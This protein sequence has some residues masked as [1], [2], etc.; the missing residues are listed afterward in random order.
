MATQN[1]Q[2]VVT[3]TDL[4]IRRFKRNKTA[5]VGVFL[6]LFVFIFSFIGPI[7]NPYSEYGIFIL[8][9]T[10]KDGVTT[11]EEL[12]ATDVD[13]SAIQKEGSKATVNIKAKPS[14]NHLLGTD[15]DGRDVFTRLMYGGRIS[16]TVG[17]VAVAIQLLIGITLG[18]IAGYY[19]KYI[20]GLIMRVVDIVNCLPTLP[21][22]MIL[23]SAM[24]AVKIP[25][26]QRI[27]YLMI[28][29]G[30]LSSPSAAR[31]IRGQILS[32]RELE[33]MYA[34]EAIGLKTYQKIIKHL[35][36][37]VM[38]QIIVIATLS[39]GGVILLESSLSFLGIGLAFPY[40]SWGNMVTIIN[41]RFVMQ[42]VMHAW[43]P[44]GMLILITVL[45][46]NF[47]GDGLRDAF[48]P[49]MNR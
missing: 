20:D 7:F 40:A 2:K 46:L 18:G 45:G 24:A 47:V 1:K 17:F 23:S 27:Y 38:P 8:K 6:I 13:F 43:I 21:L 9:T 49:R 12:E 30:I 22:L 10:Q 34:T 15:P 4:V 42:N 16:L 28:V 29:I 48:D 3:P 26:E 14:K 37:N 5:V 11:V 44:P 39:I 31:M 25:Q 33:Y 36:P 19:G 32:I 35:I 41:D